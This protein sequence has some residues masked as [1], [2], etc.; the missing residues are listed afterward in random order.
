MDKKNKK[1]RLIL[2]LIGAFFFI[3]AF[4]DFFILLCSGSQTASLFPCLG[5][6]ALSIV[7]FILAFIL[8]KTK[9]ASR[10]KLKIACIVSLSVAIISGAI[11]AVFPDVNEIRNFGAIYNGFVLF[12]FAPLMLFGIVSLI[13]LIA[14]RKKNIA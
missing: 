5:L 3:A 6:V 7:S 10:K 14:T 1:L 8:P 4:V 12:T 9:T 13:V 11:W 2:I